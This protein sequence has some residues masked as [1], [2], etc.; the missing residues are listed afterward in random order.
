MPWEAFSLKHLN[1]KLNR[2]VAWCVTSHLWCIYAWGF[3]C[4][5]SYFCFESAYNPNVTYFALSVEAC[6]CECRWNAW[7]LA[8]YSWAEGMMLCYWFCYLSICSE[9]LFQNTLKPKGLHKFH[10]M[11]WRYLNVWGHYILMHDC[12]HVFT[13]QITW[14][15]FVRIELG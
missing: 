1:L 11:C 9:N 6:Y 13:S 4:S 14:Y 12:L 10:P 7:S 15:E 2:P 3:L 8:A 5:F